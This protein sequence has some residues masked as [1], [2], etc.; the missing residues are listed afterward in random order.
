M[1]PVRRDNAIL[2]VGRGLDWWAGAFDRASIPLMTK[3]NCG[4]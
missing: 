1:N 4:L 2:D 3:V